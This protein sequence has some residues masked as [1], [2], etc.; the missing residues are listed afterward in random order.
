MK[1]M[2]D[3]LNEMSHKAKEA[4]DAVEQF[5]GENRRKTEAKRREL[6]A[7]AR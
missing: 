1:K 7:L 5:N 2:S 6:E 4:Q 3:L